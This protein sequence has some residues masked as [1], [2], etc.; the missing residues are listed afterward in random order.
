VKALVVYYSL[1]GQAVVAADLAANAL[2][3]S[4]YQTTLCRVDFADPASRPKRPFSLRDVKRWS[5]LAAAGQLFPIVLEPAD[6]VGQRYDLVIL[7]SNTW[8][9]HP[10]PPIRSL[11]RL[12]AMKQTL[13]DTPFAV[14]VV[15]RLLWEKNAQIV[16]TDAEASGGRWI[17]TQHFHHHGGPIGSLLTTVLYMMRAD[18]TVPWP[19]PRFGLADADV[20]RVQPATRAIVEKARHWRQP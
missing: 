6:A 13:K 15:S 1:T 12:P 20:A 17:G 5:D 10:C 7:F 3:D 18:D 16:R 2:R 4:G 19:L 9:H 11:L 8:Q 14:Y